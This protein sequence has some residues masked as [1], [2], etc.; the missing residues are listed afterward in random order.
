MTFSIDNP[1]G[2]KQPSFGQYVKKK[3]NPKH[4]PRA[5][6]NSTVYYQFGQI[7]F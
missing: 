3:K 6:V 5:R 2:L 7:H 4:L 1:E